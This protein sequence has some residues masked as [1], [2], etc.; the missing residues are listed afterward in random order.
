MTKLPEKALLEGTKEPETTTGE[1]RLAMGNLRQYLADLLGEESSDR[2]LARDTLGAQEKY[3]AR[4]D[5]T[6]DAITAVFSHPVIKLLDGMRVQVMARA[7]NTTTTPTFKADETSALVIV[8]GSDEPLRPGDI[9][10]GGHWL[11]L[12]YDD[13]LKKWVL[14]NPAFG[15]SVMPSIEPV[16]EEKA[17]RLELGN[18]LSVTGG[19]MSGELTMQGGT[20]INLNSNLAIGRGY[21]HKYNDTTWLVNTNSAGATSCYVSLSDNGTIELHGNV[22][23]NNA[24]LRSV[25]AVYASG[26]NWYRKW[27]DGWLEQGGYGGIGSRAST[28]VTF[29]Q[30]FAVVPCV[31]VTAVNHV[32][33]WN[34]AA[35]L[36][37]WDQ[38][39][40][41]FTVC[42]VSEEFDSYWIGFNWYACGQGA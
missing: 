38:N 42:Q 33:G 16:L 24:S 6:A 10:G 1:F 17:D 19:V 14:Q 21:L 22:S 36:G 35:T 9:A 13:N 29:L 41:N 23:F 2:Q 8:K 28:V 27:S 5:G 39:A 30:S 26:S 12:Q 7:P 15:V 40:T 4:A 32:G 25:T 37:V 11:E 18:Y 31:N 3:L 34:Y 20:K